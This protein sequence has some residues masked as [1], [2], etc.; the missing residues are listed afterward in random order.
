LAGLDTRDPGLARALLDRAVEHDVLGPCFPLLQSSVPLDANG[1][2]RLTR[3]L[4]GERAP[5]G[6]YQHLA[7]GR[8]TDTISDDRL[9]ALLALI[10]AKPGGHDV[11]IEILSMRLHSDHA[12]HRPADPDLAAAGRALFAQLPFR[13]D[14]RDDGYRLKLVAKAA[15]TG[16]EGA[17]TTRLVWRN[18]VAAVHRQDTH[19]FKQHGLLTALFSTQPAA[20]LDEITAGDEHT[21]Q[22][23][24]RLLRDAGYVE[25]NPVDV[26]PAETL[27]AW[28]RAA[29]VTRFLKASTIITPVT[30][31]ADG[32]AAQ[33]TP[34][35]QALLEEASDR[36]AVLDQFL[37]RFRPQGWSGSLAAIL[38]S[39][40]AL[41]LALGD[42]R[43]R[44][45][46]EHAMRA[47]AALQQQITAERKW[48]TEVHRSRDERFE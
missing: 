13:L 25:G 10:A 46:A 26:I 4:A 18:L 3:A 33:W 2:A 38:D 16:A 34:A 44:H 1:I 12:D 7:Y 21:T 36:A 24:L 37:S 40:A 19:A 15:L 47:H 48:E 5:I 35:A 8:F 45:L 14:D 27:L 42:H 9:R 28:C 17:E 31:G 30:G 6:S 23:M 22:G 41:L 32:A 20:L 11:A 43:D 29:P 39:R